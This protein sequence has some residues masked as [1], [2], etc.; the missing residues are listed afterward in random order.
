MG[1]SADSIRANLAQID[2]NISMG[3]PEHTDEVRPENRS[4]RE[5]VE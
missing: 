4:M 1:H 3:T 2:G 5:Y